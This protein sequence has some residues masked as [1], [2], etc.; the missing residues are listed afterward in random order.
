MVGDPKIPRMQFSGIHEWYTVSSRQSYHGAHTV[1]NCT[2]WRNVIKCL[3]EN[4]PTE[5]VNVDVPLGVHTT[6]ISI[7]F[8][9]YRELPHLRRRDGNAPLSMDFLAS[10]CRHLCF[11]AQP[12]VEWQRPLP[13]CLRNPR[14]IQVS[15]CLNAINTANN[16]FHWAESRSS[17]HTLHHSSA[18]FVARDKQRRVSLVGPDEPLRAFWRQTNY[19]VLNKELMN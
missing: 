3:G 9:C 14:I 12:P 5:E 13:A 1:T 11:V 15:M 2:L 16:G 18:T 6:L 7:F 10:S 19:H 8:A 17:P 4:F